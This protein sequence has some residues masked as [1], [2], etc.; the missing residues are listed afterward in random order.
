MTPFHHSAC[1]RAFWTITMSIML[2]AAVAVAQTEDID[3]IYATESGACEAGAETRVEISG[4]SLSGPGFDCTLGAADPVGTGLINHSAECVVDGTASSVPVTFDLGNYA[5][6]FEIALPARD[7]WLPL[8][9]CKE[10]PG[11]SDRTTKAQDSRSH[12]LNWACSNDD[13]EATCSEAGCD[14]AKAHTPMAI[15]IS[16]VQLSVCAYS[17]CWEGPVAALTKAGSLMTV[18]G[19]KLAFSNDPDDHTDISVTIDTASYAST[20]LVT[21]NYAT[22]AMCKPL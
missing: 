7:N 6:R 2:P 22:P 9:P 17:G 15:T 4:G 12:G 19:A 16:A 5:D 1:R 13:I 3:G 21:G 18:T 14:V 20:V 11:L 10:A 8:Y